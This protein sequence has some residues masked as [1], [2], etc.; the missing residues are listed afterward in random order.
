MSEVVKF[1]WQLMPGFLLLVCAVLPLTIAAGFW[2][3]DRAEQK[4]TALQLQDEAAALPPVL[5]TGL[6]EIAKSNYTKVYLDG[7]WSEAIF[8]LDNRVRSGRAGY[9]V[10]GVLRSPGLPAVMV[11][12][13]WV[14]GG[15]DRNLMPEVEPLFGTHRVEGYLYRSA[16]KPIV[17]AE[18]QWSGEYPERLQ[19]IDYN[20]LEQRVGEELYPWTLRINPE[21]PLA[22]RADWKIERKGPGMH[23]G[24]AVQW[25]L[26]S[27]TVIL[28]S[29][30]ANSN[31]WLWLKHRK[32]SAQ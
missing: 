15:L 32:T 21:S 8:M 18:Q 25:F 23:I 2:Q 28:M 9:E 24:Y 31:L 10:L 19:A 30:F 16:Q 26:M 7:Q 1:Q 4:R 27:F 13:G 14:D 29:L 17:L 12:R 5:L 11:N 22:F 3:L 20:L 6:D